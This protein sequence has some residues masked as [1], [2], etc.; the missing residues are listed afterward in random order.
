MSDDT[1]TITTTSNVPGAGELTRE[2]IARAIAQLVYRKAYG[3]RPEVR[4]ARREYNRQ[5]QADVKEALE[6]LR[7]A[8][9]EG[10]V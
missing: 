7:R 10:K 8:R 5:R 6:L 1:K 9:K 2:E 4:E 3:R